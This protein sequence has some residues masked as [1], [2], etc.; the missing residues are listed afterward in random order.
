MYSFHPGG[1]NSLACD[2]SVKFIKESVAKSTMAAYITR[3]MGEIIGAD[4]L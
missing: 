2:G 1:M 4:S 3:D